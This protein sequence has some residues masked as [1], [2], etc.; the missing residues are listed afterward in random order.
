MTH[1]RRDSC[2]TPGGVMMYR[3]KTPHDFTISVTL[4]FIIIMSLLMPWWAHST[5]SQMR[6]WGLGPLP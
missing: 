2:I 6:G 4:S 1:A 5:S 3:T